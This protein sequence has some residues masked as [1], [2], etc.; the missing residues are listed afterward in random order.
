MEGAEL[1]V[2]VVDEA[3]LALSNYQLADPIA[4]FYRDRSAD[5]SSSYGRASIILVDP[6]ALEVAEDAERKMADNLFATQSLGEGAIMEAE[7]PMQMQ[8]STV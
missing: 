8:V 2:V 4:V 1:A 5:L 6:L 3:I 7:A